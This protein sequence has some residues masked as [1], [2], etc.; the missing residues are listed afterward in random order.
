MIDTNK[1]WKKYKNTLNKNQS[2]LLNKLAE[3][4]GIFTGEFY[5][6]SQK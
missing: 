6:H 4:L 5:K 1:K 3:L 2:N